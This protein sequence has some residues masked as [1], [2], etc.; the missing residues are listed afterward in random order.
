MNKH[1][2]FQPCTTE[3]TCHWRS[4]VSEGCSSLPAFSPQGSSNSHQSLTSNDVTARV[5]TVCRYHGDRVL[6]HS[7]RLCQYSSTGIE[8]SES[9]GPCITHNYLCS[10]ICIPYSCL[11]EIAISCRWRLCTHKALKSELCIL[12]LWPQHEVVIVYVMSSNTKW[13]YQRIM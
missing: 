12:T 8:V 2:Y 13:G 9:M 11:H 4:K 10:N 6:V 7:I 3:D 5:Y 1:C